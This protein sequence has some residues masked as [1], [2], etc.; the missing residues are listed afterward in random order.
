M[1]RGGPQTGVSVHACSPHGLHSSSISAG[2]VQCSEIYFVFEDMLRGVIT[3]FS[4]DPMVLFTCASR[5]TIIQQR[6]TCPPLSAAAFSSATFA[7]LSAQ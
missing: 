2:F 1:S 3:A 6:N 4:R 7:R 5:P